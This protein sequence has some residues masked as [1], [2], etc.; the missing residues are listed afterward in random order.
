MLFSTRL[1][2]CSL[3]RKKINSV[4]N[5]YEHIIPKPVGDAKMD[6]ARLNPNRSSVLLLKK[7]KESALSSHQLIKGYEDIISSIKQ[8]TV[9]NIIKAEAYFTNR[10]TLA[11]LFIIRYNTHGNKY[12]AIIIRY[13][14]KNTPWAN[15]VTTYETNTGTIHQ[16]NG[17]FFKD[18]PY[19][20]TPN[21]TINKDSTRYTLF[22]KLSGSLK[23]V[24]QQAIAA[25]I[26]AVFSN[27]RRRKTKNI[28]KTI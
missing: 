23:K 24:N 3:F 14:F 19:F 5:K 26:I 10:L 18:L 17:A 9:T 16:M 21:N 4:T 1:S 25:T 27:L 7:V 12:C 8:Y 20:F 13:C 2:C 6:C 22:T 11:R 28:R 15:M